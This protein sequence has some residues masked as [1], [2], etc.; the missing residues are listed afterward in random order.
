M[1]VTPFT[2]DRALDAIMKYHP[3]LQGKIKLQ[4]GGG[5]YSKSQGKE[6]TDRWYAAGNRAINI[7]L[8]C[9]IFA[10][11]YHEMG[12]ASLKHPTQSI[13]KY[14]T[15]HK[16]NLNKKILPTYCGLF[17][18]SLLYTYSQKIDCWHALI[19][20]LTFIAYQVY[21]DR[22]YPFNEKWYEIVRAHEKEADESIPNHLP[23]LDDQ[24]K[25]LKEGDPSL[26]FG[27]P[28]K[29]NDTHPPTN[30]RVERLKDRYDALRAGILLHYTHE[31]IAGQSKIP[32]DKILK[33]TMNEKDFLEKY[34]RIDGTSPAK[35]AKVLGI[36]TDPYLS[37]KE[38]LAESY[39]SL[40]I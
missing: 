5:D 8:N 9:R 23:I 34:P 7:P 19:P 28:P 13:K 15:Y 16:N 3:G 1:V 32:Q 31:K 22:N 17:F 4:T 25:Y 11:F 14:T 35:A 18:G 40:K 29:W 24:M 27:K 26:K 33:T 38:D 21:L 20:P 37:L 36:S 39:G 10:P 6:M 12:H 2:R 30:Q